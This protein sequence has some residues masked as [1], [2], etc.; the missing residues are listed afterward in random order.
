MT[1]SR[2]FIAKFLLASLNKKRRTALDAAGNLMLRP[3]RRRCRVPITGQSNLKNRRWSPYVRPIESKDRAKSCFREK[4][5]GP[6]EANLNGAASPYEIR[7][8]SM[9]DLLGKS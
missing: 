1:T 6:S 3:G 4:M 5:Q 7:Y 9:A 2:S 8:K